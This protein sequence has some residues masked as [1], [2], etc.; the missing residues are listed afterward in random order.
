[1]GSRRVPSPRS[2]SLPGTV[3]LLVA[4][5]I[6]PTPLDTMRRRRSRP[7]GCC[8]SSSTSGRRQTRRRLLRE[9][10]YKPR[11]SRRFVPGNGALI[12]PG[13][14][15]LAQSPT[16]AFRN[17]PGAPAPTE[18]VEGRQPPLVEV[19]GRGF[20]RARRTGDVS[21]RRHVG[22]RTKH[23]RDERCRAP[24]ATTT[25]PASYRR[26]ALLAAQPD[27][28]SNGLWPDP[29]S[30]P[31][32]GVLRDPQCPVGAGF[33][34]AAASVEPLP[35]LSGGRATRRPAREA[36]GRSGTR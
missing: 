1:M 32:I 24:R 19:N 31:G 33:P 5:R 26:V 34:A 2:T 16:R 9:R 17:T 27:S 8:R 15:S 13:K 10:R 21:A 23:G 6:P 35:R 7:A 29:R 12:D 30:G 4:L 18:P 25:G 3:T 22:D 20:Q 36:A 11:P 14:G 28:A